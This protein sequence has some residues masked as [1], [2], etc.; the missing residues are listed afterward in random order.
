MLMQG[1]LVNVASI[2][3]DLP[4]IKRLPAVFVSVGLMWIFGIAK[5]TN[6]EIRHA[7]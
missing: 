1:A 6:K 3:F 4:G 2:A 7:T 5:S